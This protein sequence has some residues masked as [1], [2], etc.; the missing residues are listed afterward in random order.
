MT[1]INESQRY[2]ERLQL[3]RQI[4]RA[5]LQGKSLKCIA[6]RVVESV[7]PLIP[8]CETVTITSYDSESHLINILAMNDRGKIFLEAD[9]LLPMNQAPVDPDAL[10][11]D[12]VVNPDLSSSDLSDGMYAPIKHQELQSALQLPLLVR[13]Q[14]VGHFYLASTAVAAFTEPDIELA[15]ELAD[16]LAIAIGWAQMYEQTQ[17]ELV[18]REQAETTLL[19]YKRALRASYSGIIICDARQPDIPIVY[20]NSAFE[21]ITGYS[22]A[23]VIGQNCRFLNRRYRNQPE[24]V[25]VRTAIKE[26][27]ACKI[28]LK[29]TRQDGADFW[30]ELSISP[31]HNPKGQLT[32]FIGIHVD[33]TQQ[34]VMKAAL[35]KSE[36]QLR[37]IISSISD[38]IYMF[39]VTVDGQLEVLFDSPNLAS[40]TG[41][42]YQTL[43]DDCHFVYTHAVHPDDKKMALQLFEQFKQG[44]SCEGEYRLVRQDG[45]VIWVRDRAKAETQADGSKII[46]GVTSEITAYKKA[47]IQLRESETFLQSI[48]DSVQVGIFVINVTKN[49]QF[50]YV[51][52]NPIHE[53]LTGIHSSQI[54]NKTPRALE[55]ILLPEQITQMEVNYQ[56]CV[57]AREMIQYEE[58]LLFKGQDSWWLTRLTPLLDPSGRVWRIV[59]SAIEI[60]DL[61]DAQNELDRLYNIEQRRRAEAEA[62]QRA[63]LAVISTVDLDQVMDLILLEL[64]N[65]VP[66]DSASVQLLYGD[67][68]QVI[69]GRGFKDLANQLGA[70]Y[71]V[72]HDTPN[73]LVMEQQEPVIIGD[74]KATYRKRF[75]EASL[76]EVHSWLGVPL[77]I[78]DEPIGMFALDKHQHDFYMDNH[79][80][81]AKSYATQAAIA[82]Q[83]AQ[84][85][86]QAQQELA[87]RKHAE[88]ILRRVA[89]GISGEIGEAFFASL[90]EHLT[91]ALDVDYAFVGELNKSENAITTLAVFA[92]HQL[93]E[94]FSYSLDGAPCQNVIL[95]RQLHHYFSD[96]QQ[97]FPE[98][99]LLV[100]LEVESYIGAPLF[101]AQNNIV[102]L[103]AMMDRNLLEQAELMESM[104][105]IFAIRAS[106]EMQRLRAM[107]ELQSERA[108]LA[109]RVE[110]RTLEL[111]TAND[112]LR[113]AIQAKDEFLAMMSHELRTPL[114]AV[115]GMSQ[116]LQECL[117]GPLNSRQQKYVKIIAD[118]GTHLLSLINDILDIAKIDAKKIRIETQPVSVKEVSQY[119]LMMIKEMAHKKQL[120]VQFNLD[121]AVAFIDADERRLK[122][123]FVNLLTN[124]VK[125]TPEGGQIGLDVSGNP[126]KGTAC[127]TV[128]DTGI[129]IS[130]E[131]LE[132]MFQPFV[133]I[134]SRLARGHEGT[135]LGLYL[136]SQ[137]T[138]MHKGTIQVESKLEQ[139][140]RFAITLPWKP[141]SD[142]RERGT[143]F[144]H[145]NLSHDDEGQNVSA[146]SPPKIL[147]VEDNEANLLTVVDYLE[148]H[149]YQLTTARNGIE[150]VDL[151]QQIQPDLILMDVQ[152]PYKDGL[153]TIQ[154]LRAT[155]E[156]AQTPIIVLTA[157]TMPGD[158][159]RC[160]QAGANDYIAKPIRMKHLLKK[161]E[162]YLLREGHSV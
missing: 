63:T 79:A 22:A 73:K 15:E 137:L 131:N 89:I 76:S 77:L 114:N 111:R 106:A 92:D 44:N 158:E 100:D 67:Y 64:Q 91:T 154:E 69:G 121:E 6:K 136:V 149:G 82:I 46:Y 81:L 65:V 134:D 145:D 29:N 156:F 88:A 113:Q 125:F 86:Q 7:P 21:R 123:I 162:H 48:Y 83:K 27:Q 144:R 148:V 49:G 140:S 143:F 51:G 102:G 141:V 118:S 129:G 127:F 55:A 57:D 33:V 13:E 146:T 39:K 54:A 151:A 119:C 66:Y 72:K 1:D 62:L 36:N 2:T 110:E 40:M 74:I 58:K 152:M 142:D 32:H 107:T 103:L 150:A 5:M 132:L 26:G 139:G 56:R 84:L 128:W 18:E 90:V 31:I 133:Q 96:V 101:D 138:D 8:V 37:Q 14:L 85:Y 60:S 23:E 9:S 4:D 80:N 95:H 25:I 161:V 50:Y 160:L 135:G 157:Q 41:Y 24:L 126:Q 94:N 17:Q 70:K 53:T 52:M 109:H 68:L 159:T 105:G 43:K 108:L 34:K 71:S 153:E 99:K 122:Q 87:E 97:Q 38:H 28:T 98:D 130:E 104:L 155:V 116:I 61:R 78:Q 10:E 35:E 112:R 115:I 47:E 75:D 59:G 147:L 42:P 30:N 3:L 124:A 12:M 120:T 93:V 11:K 117:F 16:R 19:L 45:Q 20:V